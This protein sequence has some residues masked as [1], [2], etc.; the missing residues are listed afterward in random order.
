MK[1][2]DPATMLKYCVVCESELP[3][4]TTSHCTETSVVAK[5][6]TGI[7]SKRSVFFALDG[8]QLSEA[9]FGRLRASE[10][11]KAAESRNVDSGSPVVIHCRMC[12]K[13]N[14]TVREVGFNKY[15]LCS[16]ACAD[17]LD[18]SIIARAMSGYRS[19]LAFGDGQSLQSQTNRYA[20]TSFY[21][22]WCGA[23]MGTES[24]Y[25]CPSCGGNL[26]V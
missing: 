11:K 23:N 3:P 26:V 7:L 18:K 24:I 9:D 2:H 1:Q 25:E 15:Y 12:G 22:Y 14:A 8:A 6:K 13:K 21:C 10:K 4:S 17:L 16:D 5:E 19:T 20:S